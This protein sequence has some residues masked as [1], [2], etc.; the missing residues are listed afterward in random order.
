MPNWYFSCT[1]KLFVIIKNVSSTHTVAMFFSVGINLALN[2]QTWQ[3]S[4]IGTYGSSLAVDGVASTS[5]T[6]NSC[7]LTG[8]GGN[9]SAWFGVDLGALYNVQ[10]VRLTNRDSLG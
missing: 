6:Q 7:A 3:S 10:G 5:L 9:S 1:S 2:K 8:V 4:T